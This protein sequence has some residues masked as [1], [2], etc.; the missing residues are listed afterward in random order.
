MN[1]RPPGRPLHRP[2]SR[3]I[4]KALAEL[5][6]R[7]NSLI[8]TLYGD[9]IAPHG[10]TVW[11]GSLI[12]LVGALGISDRAVRTS[13]FRLMQEGWLHATP[14]GRRSAYGLTPAGSRRIKHAYRRIYDTPQETWDGEWQIVIVPDGVLAPGERDALRRDL[15]WDGY[16]ALAPGIFAH[17]S[18]NADRLREALSQTGSSEQVAV[19]KARS[20]DGI[21]NQPL[22]ALVQQCWHLDRLADDYRRFIERFQPTLKWLEPEQVGDAEQHFVLRALLIHEFRRV[23]L[24]D[25]NLPDSL[26]AGDWPGHTARELCRTLY[27]RTLPLSE[28]HLHATLETPDGRLPPADASFHRRFGGL[29]E[30]PGS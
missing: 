2:F 11:L 26:L 29:A 28:Q 17:P 18:G 16:G 27:T 7:T 12:D 10:G 24:R 9:A 19:L 3:W 23:Q 8:M 5:P 30:V 21:A 25:P 15:L 4:D 14:I 6:L 13:V 1:S 20:L 22:C